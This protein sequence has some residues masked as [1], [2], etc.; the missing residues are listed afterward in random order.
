MVMLKHT[1][2]RFNQTKRSLVFTASIY[3]LKHT[4]DQPMSNYRLLNSNYNFRVDT[5]HHFNLHTVSLCKI[6][7]WEWQGNSLDF[8][9]Y[10]FC[11]LE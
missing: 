11:N 1:A 3:R 9:S 4:A 2:R 8:D 7:R 6:L 10:D 5:F